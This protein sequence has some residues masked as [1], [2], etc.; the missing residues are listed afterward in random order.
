LRLLFQLS[1]LDV[2]LSA[3]RQ[4]VGLCVGQPAALYI[5]VLQAAAQRTG[6]LT[7]QLSPLLHQIT[8]QLQR[9]AILAGLLLRRL[10]RVQ[11]HRRVTVLSGG[12]GLGALQPL[13]LICNFGVAASQRLALLQVLKGLG[14]R[15]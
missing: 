5:G 1:Q 8:Q 15:L 6:L 10:Q 14:R 13:Q 4:R 12:S 9:V 7:L 3:A 2:Q 11:V